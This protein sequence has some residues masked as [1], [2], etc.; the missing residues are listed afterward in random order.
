[1]ITRITSQTQLRHAQSALYDSLAQLTATQDKATSKQ[2]ISRPSDDPTGTANAL[3]VR[4]SQSANAQYTRNATDGNSWLTMVDSSLSSVE[5]IMQRV[6]DLTVKGANDGSM[7]PTAKDALASELDG[8]KENLLSLAN[9]QLLGRNVFAGT[10]S[11]AVAFRPDYSY[12]G[13]A[14]DS[15]Q[16]RI[17]QDATVRVD[18][19]G[20]AIF[21]V[22][23]GSVF[24]L[25]DQISSDLRSGTNVAP[26]LAQIDDRMT[27]VLAQHAV[28]GGA[29]NQVQRAQNDLSGQSV[30]LEA[31]RSSIEDVDLGSVILELQTRRTNYQAALYVTAQALPPTLMDFLR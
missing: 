22:G 14:G 29:E 17:S 21:G 15:V 3:A 23:S 11:D 25:I 31:Q 9:T 24:A 28:I 1:M 7:S 12:T 18:G 10:S 27:A 13:T 30:S 26:R 2:N 5:A 8:L 16:R 19:D 20:A 6:R 4:S